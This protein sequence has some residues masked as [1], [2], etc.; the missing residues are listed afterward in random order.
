[1]WNRR[2]LDV[3]FR[4]KEGPITGE[5]VNSRQLLTTG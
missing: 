2:I 1:V 3:Y 5:F 4:I